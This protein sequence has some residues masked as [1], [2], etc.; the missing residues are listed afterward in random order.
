MSLQEIIKDTML[1]NSFGSVCL[2]TINSGT[3][4]DLESLISSGA[5]QFFE[6]KVLKRTFNGNPV[7]E[8]LIDE[9]N[10]QFM[11]CAAELLKAQKKERQARDNYEESFRATNC[12]ELRTPI[13]TQ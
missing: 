5:L 13:Q 9:A 4:Y 12:H 11:S 7:V 8:V 2:Y 3:S 6:I 1:N 10:S